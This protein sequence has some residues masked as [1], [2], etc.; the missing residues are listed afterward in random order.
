MRCETAAARVGVHPGWLVPDW[1]LRQVDALMTTRAGGHSAAPF[2]SLNL[3]DG[4]GDD[5]A[6]VIRNRDRLSGAL[7]GARP[8]FLNQ[9]H[10]A[11]VVRLLA[12]DAAPDGPRHEADAC[13]TTEPGIACTIQVADCLPVLFV[14]RD[15]KAVGAAHAGWRGLAS[16][17]LETTVATLCEAASCAPRELKAWLG[18]CIGPDRFEVGADVL[19]ALAVNPALP[20]RERFRPFTSGKWLAN[21]PLLAKD[22]LRSAGIEA[23]SGGKWCTVDDASRFFSFRRDR[24]T[25]RMVAAVWIRRFARSV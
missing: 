9:V 15:G 3:H 24:T 8:V 2:D 23:I 22:R 18:A 1:R 12:H 13:V 4:L 5:P 7:G 11:R 6:A 19:D 20:D 16:G 10:G 17:V 21:L 14:A 25:G